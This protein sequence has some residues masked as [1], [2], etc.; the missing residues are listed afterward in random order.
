VADIRYEQDTVTIRQRARHIAAALGFDRQDQIRIATAVSEVAR[1][2]LMY[3]GGGTAEFEIE[4]RTAP[5]V[6]VISVRDEGPGIRDVELVLGGNYQSSTGMGIG[7]RGARRLM[8]QCEIDSVLGRGTTVILKKLLSRSAPLV[9]PSRIAEIGA[10]V[11]PEIAES[12]FHELQHQNQELL[13]SLAVLKDRQDDLSRVNRELEDTNRGV[14]ALYAELD[15]KA[16]HLRRADAMKSRFLSNM[17]HEF[18]TPLHSILA[19]TQLLSGPTDGELAAE[20]RKQVEL[21]AK[22]ASSLLELVNDLLDLAKIEAGK[23]EVHETEFEVAT[24]FSALRG[25]LRPLLVSTAVE[26]VFDEP[27]DLPMLCTDEGK[28][29]QILRN[30]LSNALKYTERGEIRVSAAR[31]SDSITFRVAD[32]GIGIPADDQKRMFEEFVQIA[33]PLQQRVKGTGLGLP[34]CSRLTSLLGGTIGVESDLGVGSTFWVTLPIRGPKGGSVAREPTSSDPLRVPVLLVEDDSTAQAIYQSHVAHTAFQLIP[35]RSIRDA[36]E[37]LLRHR[38]AAIILDLL[39]LGEDSWSFLSEL[40]G[41]PATERI[42]VIVVTSVDDR[43]KAF[44]LGADAYFGKPIDR[45]RLL[46]ELLTLTRA[47]LDRVRPA[48]VVLVVDDQESARYVLR[49]LLKSCHVV[50]AATAALARERIARV[51]PDLV[52][53][54]LGLP[55]GAGEDILA[56]L[57]ADARTADLPVVV[58]TS[59]ILSSSERDVILSRATTLLSKESMSEQAIRE[60][61]DRVAAR[62]SAG[63]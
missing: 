60:A 9:G 51:Q 42:P 52:F 30:F 27:T 12:P 29:S 28:V 62:Q 40:K 5:Q 16:D 61:I 49:R 20:H 19:L 63:S 13:H 17:S 7:L 32:T 4:G 26:L 41:N 25:M 59:K 14:I 21:I 53:L 22:S 48:P 50:E 35:T 39:L 23:V 46:A 44:A 37:A 36:R 34:L 24:L 33:N 8:D 15:D 1:N 57:R 2:A 6:L 11:G 3:A 38:P 18:R 31:S 56:E 45:D 55:D 10:L 47:D 58:I 54:D 43:R